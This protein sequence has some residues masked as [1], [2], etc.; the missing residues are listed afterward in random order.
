MFHLVAAYLC[1]QCSARFLSVAIKSPVTVNKRI[2]SLGGG[3]IPCSDILPV[4]HS[5]E[6][7]ALNALVC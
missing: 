5:I 4:I 1:R 3:L 2:P 6:L 7:D